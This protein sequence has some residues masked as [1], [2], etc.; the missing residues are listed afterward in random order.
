MYETVWLR[1]FRLLFGST[2]YAASAILFAFFTGLAIGSATFGRLVGRTRCPPLVLYAWIEL[3]VVATALMVPLAV[4]AYD[5][6]YAELYTRLADRREL[7]VAVK[8]FLALV[9]MLPTATLLGGTLPVLAAAFVHSPRNLGREG[10]LLYATNTLG[11]VFGVVLAALWLPEWVGVRATYGVA[12]LLSLALGL[13]A[14][15]LSRGSDRAPRASPPRPEGREAAPAPLLI[16]AFASGFGTLA[17]EVLLIHALAQL[18]LNSVYSFG[19]ILILVL[20]CLALGAALVAAL[21]GR[22]RPRPFL[23]AALAVEAVLLFLLPWAMVLQVR[24]SFD[25]TVMDTIVADGLLRA[26]PLG[27]PVLL[28]GAL[29]L[30][31]TFQLAAGGPVGR[32]LGGL[33]AANTV[34]GIL[35]SF[36]AGFVMLGAIGLWS[37]FACLGLGYG[38]ASLL[39]GGRRRAVALRAAALV[40]VVAL[41]LA[42]SANPGRLPVLTLKPGQQ[43]VALAQEADGVIAVIEERN[44]NRRI[45]H[46]GVYTVGNTSLG[47]WGERGGHLPLLLHPDPKRVLFVGAAT[48]GTAG[49]AVAHPV[50]EIVLVEIVPAIQALAAEYFDEANRG[51]HS[52]PRTRLV[53]EDG[54]NHVRAAPEKYDVIV[55]DLFVP[56]RAGV[57]SLYTREHFEAV[58]NHLTPDGVFCQW[59]PLFQLGERE[60]AIIA[61]T[62]MD[63]F[64]NAT[65]WRHDFYAERP[66]AALIG[67]AGSPPSVETVAERAEQLAGQGIEDRWLLDPRGFW[68]FY[69][70]P[71]AA[72]RDRLEGVDRN[73]DDHPV[74]EFLAGRASK[75][76]GRGFVRREWP[77]FARA[78]VEASESADPVFPD[79][80]PPGPR[81][82]SDVA[83]LLA[84]VGQGRGDEADR[85]WAAVQEIVPPE[86]LSFDWT[87][88][89]HHSRIARRPGRKGAGRDTA[90][91]RGLGEAN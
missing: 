27:G 14:L 2:T 11:A 53:V 44:G 26:L 79:H 71:L 36:V 74:F 51:V 16:I 33:L 63:V 12:L 25:S 56:W 20:G 76:A 68:M 80:P 45:S 21:A 30:P 78:V 29:V 42:S 77:A 73:S 39:A 10:G 8:F 5:P 85:Q 90:R 62:F 82:G 48:G 7:F 50:E 28:V 57:G 60:F 1:W 13:G 6:I 59:L 87:V 9:A 38:A 32:R 89:D 84:L 72:A 3:G 40:A 65:L 35:G 19:A 47:L 55:A 91:P 31:L 61:A 18:D 64:P 88:S 46:N 37:S 75:S 43:V 83:R 15:A 4:R 67:F 69:V 23:A 58:K 81:G 66:R 49:A 34:G 24:E 41:V 70:G 17:V 22:V 54:R 52:D 86:L